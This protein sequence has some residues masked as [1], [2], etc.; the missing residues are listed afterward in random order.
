MQI[1]PYSGPTPLQQQMEWTWIFWKYALR[2]QNTDKY[3]RNQQSVGSDLFCP[4]PATLTLVPR[5][6]WHRLL[7]SS[8]ICATHS[9]DKPQISPNWVF[10][11]MLMAFIAPPIG[12]AQHALVGRFP[13][14]LWTYSPHFVLIEQRVWE[15]W[16]IMSKPCPLRKYIGPSRPFFQP[17]W[18]SSSVCPSPEAVYQIWCW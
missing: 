12:W 10:S 16:P 15:L 3:S 1:E 4:N 5:S 11:Y 6:W 2:M 7:C 17:I 13:V 8:K 18:L 14:Q 9:H